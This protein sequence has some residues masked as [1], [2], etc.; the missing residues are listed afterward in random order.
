MQRATC[1]TVFVGVCVLICVGVW[2]ITFLCIWVGGGVWILWLS[3]TIWWELMSRGVTGSFCV[4]SCGGG[5]T[6]VYSCV[7]PL[8]RRLLALC[9]SVP[10]CLC[11]KIDWCGLSIEKFQ[12]RWEFHVVYH[13][14]SGVRSDCVLGRSILDINFLQCFQDCLCGLGW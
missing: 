9:T 4:M 13:D 5:S 12:M 1:L 7:G 8:L 14:P 2:G 10:S 6:V 11:C 3:M